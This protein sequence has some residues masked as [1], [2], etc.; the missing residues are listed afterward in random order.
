MEMLLAFAV[1]FVLGGK[2]GSRDRH[3]VVDSFG[4]IRDS[5]EVAAVMMVARSHVGRTLR[6]VADMVDGS[7]SEAAATPDLVDR[8]RQLVER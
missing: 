8:V 1:G 7:R 5:E 4:A 2:G 3:D 6:E